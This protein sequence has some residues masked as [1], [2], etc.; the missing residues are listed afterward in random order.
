MDGVVERIASGVR[1]GLGA[2]GR[3]VRGGAEAAAIGNNVGGDPGHLHAPGVAGVM[4][5]G[6]GQRF[7]EQASGEREPAPPDD[8]TA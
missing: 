6:A 5:A 3:S 1:R 7:G 4:M 8:E 2:L